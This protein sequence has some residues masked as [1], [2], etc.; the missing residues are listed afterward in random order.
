M[1]STIKKEDGYILS[2]VIVFS[3]VIFS[4]LL[5]VLSFYYILNSITVKKI[6]K[7][8]LDLAC[9]SATQNF[10]Q[11]ISEYNVDQEVVVNGI[12]VNLSSRLTGLYLKVSASAKSTRDSTKIISHFGQ[13]SDSLFNNA[14]IMSTPQLQA[15]VAGKTKITGNILATNDNF[16]K[17]NIFGI[18]RLKGDFIDGK[19]IKENN[20]NQ[21]AF[22][23]SLLQA[24][25]YTDEIDTTIIINGN[26]QLTERN[27][28]T[29]I[30]EQYKINGDLSVSGN[31]ISKKNIEFIVTGSTE[32][33]DNANIDI[34]LEIATDSSL[35]I[36]SGC[37]IKNAIFIARKDVNVLGDNIFENVKLFAERNISVEGSTFLFPSIIAAYSEV[38]DTSNLNN[39]IEISSSAVNGTVMLINSTVGLNNNKTMVSVDKSS[40]IHGLIYCENLLEL[41]SP[42][43]GVVYTNKFYFYKRPTTYINWLVNVKINR[44][45]LDKWFLFPIGFSVT[46]NF[47]LIKEEWIY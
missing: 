18:P 33:S 16:R 19:I 35:T 5:S 10:I 31:I 11:N 7:K 30:Y 6:T 40:I 34:N 28:N 4:L 44:N 46:N 32:F 37:K 20:V 45:E 43:N 2:N 23:D 42:V 22:S 26:L 38:N 21:K 36:N 17:G 47:E 41:E 1:N 15:S 25:F 13:K 29:F 12:S 3:F 14:L 9:Y 24:I 27:F 8:E 39:K